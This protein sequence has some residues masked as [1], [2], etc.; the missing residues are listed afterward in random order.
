MCGVFEVRTPRKE[1]NLMDR[2]L[3]ASEASE[4]TAST[5]WTVTPYTAYSSKSRKGAPPHRIELRRIVSQKIMK[6]RDGGYVAVV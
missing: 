1:G 5:L 3:E 4:A 2:K 6:T